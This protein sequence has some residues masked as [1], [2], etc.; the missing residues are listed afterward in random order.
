MLQSSTV[1]YSIVRFDYWCIDV[2]SINKTIFLH[3][4]KKNVSYFPL[5]YTQ[6]LNTCVC[7]CVCVCVQGKEKCLCCVV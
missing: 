1:V 4:Q 3:L 5:L 6:R 7:V 2:N